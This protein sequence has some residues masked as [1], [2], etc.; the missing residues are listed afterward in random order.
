MSQGYQEGQG[1]PR[2]PRRA[3][4]PK[5]TK[6]GKVSQG[7]QEEQGVPRLRRRA[8]CP[9]ATKRGKVSQGYQEEQGSPKTKKGTLTKATKKPV[10]F[11][12]MDSTLVGV[13]C[14]R[15]ARPP[16]HQVEFIAP[17]TTFPHHG[18]PT[19]LHHGSIPAS[20]SDAGLVTRLILLQCGIRHPRFFFLI[21][22]SFDRF[23]PP[24]LG[25]SYLRSATQEVGAVLTPRTFFSAEKG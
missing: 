1:V 22:S 7:Y 5:A 4:C 25:S 14:A 9:K 23:F 8:R 6:R 12:G 20:L 13:K 10:V 19:I 2:L 3:R 17:S 15:L 18:M 11:G 21:S 16:P 24:L